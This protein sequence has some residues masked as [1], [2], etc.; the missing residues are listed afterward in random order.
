MLGTII[1]REIQEQL[2]SLKFILGFLITVG[3]IVFSVNIN[4]N[5]FIERKAECDAARVEAKGDRSYIKIYREPKL[6]SIFVLGKERKLGNKAEMTQNNIPVETT[7]YM[8]YESQY[9]RYMAGFISLDYAFV[10]RFVLSL[11]VVF[12]AFDLIAGEQAG[13][14]LKLILSNSVPRDI[15][16]LGKYIG[17]LIVISVSFL[18]ASVLSLLILL[19]N[20][21][22][23]ID[24]YSL[25]RFAALVGASLLYLTTFFS[26]GT[27]VSVLTEKPSNALMI[28]LQIWIILLIIYPAVG[29]IIAEKTYHV[30]SLEEKY[31]QIGAAIKLKESEIKK[32]EE[33]FMK[34]FEKGV[35]PT[36][37]QTADSV[38]GGAIRAEIIYDIER[39]Y[40]KEHENQGLYASNLLIFSP[41]ILYQE[42]MERLALTG[43]DDFQR[44]LDGINDY[45]KLYIEL[46]LK[47]WR[48]KSKEKLPAYQYTQESFSK[49]LIAVASRVSVMFAVNAIF[50]IAGF[51][52]FLRKEI[53]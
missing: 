48:E 17:G 25:L 30:Q 23:Q 12:F 10:V 34:A 29:N 52:A 22:I 16:I 20:S 5:D 41:P 33:P 32:K 46:T 18:I 49:S 36:R 14:T 19:F 42:I 9:N 37:E 44:F 35:N 27:F 21:A 31:R 3:L 7:G 1:I 28:M 53:R 38:E 50:F 6:L 13:G 39:E 4:L 8:G 24:P 45:W 43:M 15:L 2:K 26:I 11:M 47:K 51:T 40:I